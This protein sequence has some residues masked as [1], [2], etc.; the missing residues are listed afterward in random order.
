MLPHINFGVGETLVLGH[1][2]VGICILLP[3]I[4]FDIYLVGLVP[5]GILFIG[6]IS[7]LI[8]YNFLPKQF[9]FSI[10][11]LHVALFC[12]TIQRTGGLVLPGGSG[13]ETLNSP[14]A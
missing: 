11:L 8:V 13:N 6:N 12:R 9:C 2:I 14:T 4:D 10:L 5:A 7:Y 1:L 3:F